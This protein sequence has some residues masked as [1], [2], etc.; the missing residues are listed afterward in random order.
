[1]NLSRRTCTT[2]GFRNRSR[3]GAIRVP[4][5]PRLRGS[6]D[7]RGIVRVSP[8]PLPWRLFAVGGVRSARR[9]LGGKRSSAPGISRCAGGSIALWFG[10]LIGGTNTPS[11]TQ[12]LP[13]HRL[14]ETQLLILQV[15]VDR[16]AGLLAQLE[17]ELRQEIVPFAAIELV[18]VEHDLRA[19]RRAHRR[20]DLVG[21]HV[22]LREVKIIVLDAHVLRPRLGVRDEKCR[23]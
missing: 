11:R 3:S 1:K 19:P 9:V 17:G 22:V 7:L 10:A 2:S 4:G 21:H 16:L 13:L 23:G 15:R 14:A 20:L 12:T 18:H 8:L 6:A 5:P